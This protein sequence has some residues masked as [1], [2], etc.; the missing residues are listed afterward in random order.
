MSLREIVWIVDSVCT[1]CME[2]EW[3]GVVGGV[4]VGISLK[5]KLTKVRARQK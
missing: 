2:H 4:K 3:A 5:Q 1:L